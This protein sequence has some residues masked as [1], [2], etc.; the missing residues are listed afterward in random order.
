MSYGWS[1]ILFLV[2]IYLPSC[3]TVSPKRDKVQKIAID[4]R[5]ELPTSLWSPSKR[6][7]YAGYYFMIGEYKSLE[8]SWV[9]ANRWYEA[10]YHLDSNSFLA[11]KSISSLAQSGR[12]TDAMYRAKKIILLY[13]RDMR[14]RTLYGQLL[15]R[16]GMIEE[17]VRELEKSLVL[18]PTQTEPY[19]TLIQVH[20]YQQKPRKALVVAKDLVEKNPSYSDGWSIIAR[21]YLATKQPSNALYPAKMAYD[22]M[23]NDPEKVLVY[24]FA[25][26]MN[27]KSRQAVAL[28][29]ALFRLNPTNN[30][31][32]ARMVRLYNQIGD[33]EGAVEL[34]KE[35]SKR[36]DTGGAGAKVQLAILLWELKRFD[37]AE[38]I[39]SD[40][41]KQYPDSDRVTYMAG[42]G[43]EKVKA[44]E[45]AIATYNKIDSA[46]PFY[47]H[48]QLR[49]I[50][51]YR[52]LGKQEKSL[53]IINSHIANKRVDPEEFYSL[54]ASIYSD[55]GKPDN[56]I[57]LLQQGI[58]ENPDSVGLIFLLAVYYEKSDK[59]EDCV[60]TLRLVIEKDP[61]HSSALNYL[62]YLF[63]EQGKNL[64]E[65]E[66]LITK[67]LQ[68]KPRDGF[69]LDS[70]GWVYYKRKN[71]RKALEILLQAES[72][73][74]TEGVILEHLG[75][76]YKQIR[77]PQKALDYYRRAVKGR[78]DDRDR[79][80]VEE[81]LRDFKNTN[82]VSS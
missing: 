61:R 50:G 1:S 67:A 79:G 11:W 57:S 63:A 60:A 17:G 12:L 46:S 16:M 73:L 10:A 3:S 4:K 62:G 59:K 37:Q 9:D 39:L 65:A 15:V 49:V 76:V 13:P 22:L 51:I 27:G 77:Q 5:D 6:E 55:Q 70:L 75:D 35:V 68:I 41:H 48:A 78:L 44:F 30:E 54:G 21:L 72:V 19:L 82:A 69:Y 80:R 14:L 28:Y 23:S 34:L 18:D 38:K 8:R 58:D 24:A 43:R 7:I 36:S 20:E 71:Y 2:M 47:R 81:K 29:E 42:L 64:D 56:A 66:D 40:L 74:P 53:E 52:S 33:L 25:L 32:I 31:L 26:E 45:S